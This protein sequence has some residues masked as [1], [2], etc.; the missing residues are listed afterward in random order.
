MADP[1]FFSVKGPFT[2]AELA[3][4]GSARLYA[5]EDSG[6]VIRD[7]APLDTAGPDDI[8]FFDNPRYLDAFGR[9]GAG[10]CL[11]HPRHR[12]HAPERPALLLTET[13]Y[14]AYALVARA[15]YP[16]VPTDGHIS[17]AA[18]IHETAV[19]G[20]GTTVHAGAVIGAHV[21]T[22]RRCRIGANAVIADGVE[23]GDDTRIG[24]CASLSHCIVGCRV[25]LYAGVRIGEDGFGFAPGPDGPVNL[26]QL[27]RVII[28]DDVEIAA[29]STVDR[30]AGPDTV[31]GRGCRIDNLVQIGHNVRLGSS[32]IVVAQAGVSGSTHIGDNVMIGGQ[33]GI[34]G[35]I[36][37]GDGARIGA[38]AGVIRDVPAGASVGGSPA[39]PVK[40]WLRQSKVLAR[41]TEKKAGRNG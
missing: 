22:G 20:E 14:L 41:L 5:E 8:S 32:G 31:I 16:E 27:G 30:G 25:R 24:D 15:F 26:P 1:R 36:T 21:K 6:T 29:N 7:V 10:A 23:I 3:E 35:H 34:I 38:Q 9:T 12:D 28:E 4:I 33:A 17:P 18:I 11:V 37:I 13:P 2:V 19:M 39:V 40:Q